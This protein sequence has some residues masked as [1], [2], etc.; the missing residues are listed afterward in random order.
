MAWPN[1][2]T[3]AFKPHT[4]TSLSLNACNAFQ[5]QHHAQRYR[6]IGAIAAVRS[7]EREASDILPSGFLAALLRQSFHDQFADVAHGGERQDRLVAI[8]DLERLR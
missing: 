8:E 6:Q 3:A 2:G 5:E 1:H 4:A 7:I